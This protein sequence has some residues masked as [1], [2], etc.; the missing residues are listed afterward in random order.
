MNVQEYLERI[1]CADC[2]K[3]STPNLADLTRLVRGNL[4][5]FPFENFDMH[6]GEYRK[7]SLEDAYD[8]LIN[9]KLGGFC[10][11]LN[12]LFAWLLNELK[13]DVTLHPAYIFNHFLKRY[14]RLPIHIVL[15][16]RLD[17]HLFYVDLGTTRLVN[18]P[19]EINVGVEQLTQLGIFKFIS[20]QDDPDYVVLH[21]AKPKTQEWVGMR[22]LKIFDYHYLS[23]NLLSYLICLNLRLFRSNSRQRTH[24][25]SAFSKE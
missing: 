15:I 22:K 14:S 5:Q 10:I 13:Y 9:R 1:G 6:M 25:N 12:G 3:S 7:F 20:A 24:T 21:R 17:G 19:I 11:Q 18:Q 2:L 16:V 4:A 23:T 8:R